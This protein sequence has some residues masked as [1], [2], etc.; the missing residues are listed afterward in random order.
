MGGWLEVCVDMWVCVWGVC[1]C[2]SV[3]V[4]CVGVWGVYVW[5]CVC[6]CVVYVCLW[7]WVC[8]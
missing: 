5:G 7:V 2:V 3:C 1:V 4:V 8:L 6:E